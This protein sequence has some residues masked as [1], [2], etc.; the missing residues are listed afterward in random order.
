M[1]DT[2]TPSQT[3]VCD[4]HSGMRSARHSISDPPQ[5][6]TEAELLDRARRNCPAA[7]SA[8]WGRHYRS[9]C[10]S[11]A[12]VTSRF[13]PED[14]AAEAFVNLLDALRAGRGP[15][16]AAGPYL[17]ATVQHLSIRW[18]KRTEVTFADPE[19]DLLPDPADRF[20][21]IDEAD[22][23]AAAAAAFHSLSERWRQ[24]L[25]LTDL[26]GLST[27]EAGRIL[28]LSSNAVSQLRWRAVKG[29]RK[30]HDARAT[31]RPGIAA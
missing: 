26:E 28:S 27:I 29:L 22:D 11:A 20:T 12:R 13:D 17:R 24:V 10:R 2:V 1:Y 31:T 8:L 23:R 18:A 30:A 5:D 19:L 3:P 21:A 14:L 7:V 25:W 6:I 9:L 16:T 4:C 15:A